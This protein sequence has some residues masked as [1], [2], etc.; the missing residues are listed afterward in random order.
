MTMRR[1]ENRKHVPEVGARAASSRGDGSRDEKD[2]GACRPA[3]RAVGEQI[4]R[5][6]PPA[7]NEKDELFTNDKV[8]VSQHEGRWLFVRYHRDDRLYSGWVYDKYITK[9]APGGAD[10]GG[11]SSPAHVAGA[12]IATGA[13]KDGASFI[14]LNGVIDFGDGERFAAVAT[15]L[16]SRVRLGT[17]IVVIMT[18]TGGNLDAGI[19][20][21]E[22]IYDHH[23]ETS[24][25]DQC[26]SACALAWAA[27]KVKW[28][29]PSSTVAFHSGF[30]K[31]SPDVADG[32]ASALEGAYLREIGISVPVISALIGHDPKALASANNSSDSAVTFEFPR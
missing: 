4:Q 6:Q 29:R 19:K 10:S 17:R 21:G 3:K 20:I 28:I 5:H 23:Y 13:G 16:E 8:C 30:I 14:S 24:A 18:S 1:E 32:T 2:P 15:G 7:D 31:D 9:D 26:F 11:T 22:F 12:D 27:G 25:R